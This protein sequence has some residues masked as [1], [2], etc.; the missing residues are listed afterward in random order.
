MGR[1]AKIPLNAPETVRTLLE[2]LKIIRVID[3]GLTIGN[4][5]PG[6]HVVN[7]IDQW[8]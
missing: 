3:H 6:G 2:K 4:R 5:R 8:P 7:W 1:S